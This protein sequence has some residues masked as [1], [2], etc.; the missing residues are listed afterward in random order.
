MQISIQK[1]LLSVLLAGCFVIGGCTVQ[2][3]TKVEAADVS[4]V[5]KGQ[6]T[7]AELINKLGAPTTSTVDAAGKETLI[8]EHYKHTSDA[9]TFIPFAGLLIGSTE[10][11]GSTF[12]VLLDRNNRVADYQISNSRS[13]GK[14]GR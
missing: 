5:K 8:W 12:T 10:M 3:G 7:K 4:F 14:V 2:Q 13:E 6:T 9:K 11:Q 1:S